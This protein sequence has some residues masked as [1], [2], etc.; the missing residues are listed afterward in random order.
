MTK[1][2]KFIR[3]ASIIAGY[4]IFSRVFDKLIRVDMVEEEFADILKQCKP[5]TLTS[6]KQCML[7]IKQQNTSLTIIFPGN[8]LSVVSGGAGVQCSWH[9]P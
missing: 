7:Y 3:R 6:V 5:F 1:I 8:L 2:E 9:I 4:E